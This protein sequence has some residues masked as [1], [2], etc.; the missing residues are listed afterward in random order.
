MAVL[1]YCMD[2]GPAA[3]VVRGRRGLF[4]KRMSTREKN[5]EQG[6]IDT[7]LIAGDTHV[8]GAEEKAEAPTS[9][10]HQDGY[11]ASISIFASLP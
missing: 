4:E 2:G 8:F 1:T 6:G 7:E 10:Q 3:V 9:N 11:Q 5:K